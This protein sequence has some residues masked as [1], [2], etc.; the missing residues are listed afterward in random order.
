MWKRAGTWS[1][2]SL[3]SHDVDGG[4]VTRIIMFVPIMTGRMEVL[5]ASTSL[6]ALFDS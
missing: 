1:R 6:S 5:D 4:V 2:V 3:R